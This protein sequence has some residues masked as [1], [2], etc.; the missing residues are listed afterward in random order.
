M[1]TDLARSPIDQELV[2]HLYTALDGPYAPQ[3]YEQ[4]RRIWERCRDELGMDQPIAGT[5]LPTALPPDPRTLVP[6]RPAAAQELPT[7]DFQAV[8]RREHDVV[9]LS[10]ALAAPLGS[11]S[12]RLRIGSASPPG[13][14]EFD[15]WWA[16]L[17]ADGT[18]A[19]LGETRVYQAKFVGA[20]IPPLDLAAAEVRRALPDGDNAPYWWQRGWTTEQGFAVWE[21]SPD[22]TGPG[23][24]IVVLAPQDQDA[25]L[26]AW[27]WSQ[28]QPDM[29]PLC[30]YSLHAAKLRYQ[31]RVRGDGEVIGTLIR[32]V[33]ERTEQLPELA[34]RHPADAPAEL[35]ALR[36]DE[37]RL[38]LVHANVRDM[39]QTVR[40]AVDNMTKDRAG[41]F[42][43]DREL[44]EWLPRQLGNDADYLTSARLRAEDLRRLL[45]PVPDAAGP[46]PGA[47]TQR[48]P[49]QP[50]GDTQRGP[51][52]P[53]GGSVRSSAT[54]D[55]PRSARSPA[56][57]ALGPVG[58][59]MGFA[60]D[61]EG[62]SRRTSPEQS[63]LQFRLAHLVRQV[64]GGLGI[65]LEETD[66]QGTGDGMNIFLPDKTELHRALPHVLRS[67]QDQLGAD[68]RRFRDRMRLR[69]ATVV[70]PVGIGAL[71]YSGSGIIKVSRMLDS[72][73]LRTALRNNPQ[74]DFAALVS[75]PL[76]EYVVGEGYPGLDPEQFRRVRAEFKE[77]EAQAWLW[78]PA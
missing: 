57:G 33:V 40:I 67:W 3:G 29:P 9:N 51:S 8:V 74:V 50:S 46:Q 64:L 15:R 20:D 37:A 22:D 41:L 78:L 16:G 5:G 17:T 6:G 36:D 75:D 69:L 43:T 44:A 2:V 31:A 76:Y 14:V 58:L 68:N 7:A 13:W 61:I 59:R 54:P 38:A 56:D 66:H 10:V 39:L 53:G 32:R 45:G 62:Y 42:P 35:G 73:V 60:V 28:G 49:S 65:S 25:Q 23:R 71:G 70:G 26:S 12:R 21:L 11:A 24:R 47:D 34:R 30:R 19:L 63:D 72:A 48:R 18:E 77:Y 1:T 27:T 55:E 4:I 52:Q